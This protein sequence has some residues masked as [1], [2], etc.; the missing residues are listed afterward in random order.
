MGNLDKHKV[1]ENPFKVVY[2]DITTRC[3]MKCNF[4]YMNE[5]EG[6][7]ISVE[8]FEDV[9]KR[10]PSPVIFR[11]LGGEPTIHPNI[12]ELLQIARKYK[13]FPTIA[14]NGKRYLDKSFVKELK[15]IKGAYYGITMSGG[16]TNRDAYKTIDGEDCLEW[17]VNALN[18]LLECGINTINLSAIIMR[19][20]NEDTIREFVDLAENNK[21]QIRFLK[22]RPA[23]ELG[24]FIKTNPYTSKEFIKILKPK[25]FKLDTKPIFTT[26]VP[27]LIEICKSRECC[28]YFVYNNFLTVSFSEFTGDGALDCWKRGIL[29]NNYNL[30]KLFSSI[31]QNKKQMELSK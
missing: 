12:I 4:C 19:N 17:K 26:T 14:S 25:Y 6:E 13:H 23:S 22:F 24:R 3:N 15:N 27:E 21:R 2:V 30:V 9:C 31:D 16:I 20:L 7:D 10:L 1:D 29:D 11:F 28:Y 18:N 8:Y 5:I